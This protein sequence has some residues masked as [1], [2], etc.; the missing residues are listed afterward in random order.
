[1]SNQFLDWQTQHNGNT[2]PILSKISDGNRRAC[3]V[4]TGEKEGEVIVESE[5]SYTS[6]YGRVE[7]EQKS[8]LTGK[9][10]FVA[11]EEGLSGDEEINQAYF[12]D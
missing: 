6:S 12:Q 2:V 7:F 5:S 9:L 3:I 1:M 11:E 4:K 8:D 10:S